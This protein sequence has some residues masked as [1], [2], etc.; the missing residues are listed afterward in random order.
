MLADVLLSDCDI[1]SSYFYVYDLLREIL[2]LSPCPLSIVATTNALN[3]YPFLLKSSTPI[4]STSE[5]HHHHHPTKRTALQKL[6][7]DLQFSHS[8]HENHA[9]RCAEQ[10]A[11]GPQGVQGDDSMPSSDGEVEVEHC[12]AKQ[13]SRH[14]LDDN[15]VDLNPDKTHAR[16]VMESDP[17]T[18]NP[19][20]STSLP[21][22]NDILV[23]DRHSPEAPGRVVMLGEVCRPHVL[24]DPICVESEA[25]RYQFIAQLLILLMH[26]NRIAGCGGCGQDDSVLGVFTDGVRYQ[27]IRL[28][29]QYS[30]NRNTSDNTPCG[31]KYQIE[32]APVITLL[33]QHML[34]DVSNVQTL[35]GHVCSALNISATR[36]ITAD[37]LRLSFEGKRDTL[38]ST[39]AL[40][41][42]DLD[43]KLTQLEALL[44][45]ESHTE[46][47]HALPVTFPEHFHDDHVERELA[48]LGGEEDAT[49]TVLHK[50]DSQ[51]EHHDASKSDN[52]TSSSSEN[53][54]HSTAPPPLPHFKVVV[55]PPT[56]IP[57]ETSIATVT[58]DSTAATLLEA[59]RS[60]EEVV[61]DEEVN[62]VVPVVTIKT[63]EADIQ[64]LQEELPSI[65]H[66]PLNSLFKLHDERA[67][68]TVTA[69][70][71]N[72]STRSGYSSSS[73]SPSSAA[74]PSP[75]SVVVSPGARGSKPPKEERVRKFEAL[76][77]PLVTIMNRYILLEE[78]KLQLE[79]DREAKKLRN[80]RSLGKGARLECAV[81]A[82]KRAFSE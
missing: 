29:T 25:V 12:T 27:C 62:E 31:G 77:D 64:V 35:L 46:V 36:V 68:L 59:L 18:N 61:S 54:K 3:K 41:G 21:E 44:H 11:D 33:N 52:I 30:H 79:M 48:S 8:E 78:K 17:S 6:V 10:T 69:V 16:T 60:V 9:T 28:S 49:A 80:G 50:E 66:P 32:Y 57:I 45:C 70:A 74:S 55:D 72:A 39:M 38:Q 13:S 15:Q 43:S 14:H 58:S 53:E 24:A 81:I 34:P 63:L 75:S 37:Y 2:P 20:N 82:V 73:A 5:Y 42:A 65:K 22:R 4:P 56:L 40:T 47:G 26:N 76:E 71:E 7:E 19:A 51:Q 1:Y 23:F 67:D